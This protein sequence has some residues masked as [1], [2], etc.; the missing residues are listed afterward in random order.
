MAPKK[1]K[2]HI[3]QKK[4][5]SNSNKST[6]ISNECNKNQIIIVVFGALAASGVL[7]NKGVSNKTPVQLLISTKI[8][9]SADPYAKTQ[10]VSFYT[11]VWEI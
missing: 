11:Q 7:G 6:W 1:K 9:S 10:L 8:P 4:H 2:K 3:P 5:K